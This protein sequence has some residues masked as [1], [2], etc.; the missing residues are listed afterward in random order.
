MLAQMLIVMIGFTLFTDF[1][2]I[3]QFHESTGPFG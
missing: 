3:A 2:A 1:T